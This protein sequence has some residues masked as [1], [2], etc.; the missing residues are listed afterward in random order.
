MDFSEGIEKLIKSIHCDEDKY[1]EKVVEKMNIKPF[2]ITP[3][4]YFKISSIVMEH[5]FNILKIFEEN[6]EKIIFE[7]ERVK[8]ELTDLLKPYVKE[9]DK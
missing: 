6:Y 5:E 4:H 8:T 7:K 9:H 1:I 2:D 3:N